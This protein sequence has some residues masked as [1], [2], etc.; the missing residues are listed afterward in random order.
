[1]FDVQ[2]SFLRSSIATPTTSTIPSEGVQAQA[3][4]YEVSGVSLAPRPGVVIALV[5][6]FLVVALIP[7]F[8]CSP[9]PL[10][11]YPNHLARMY[12]ISTLPH[13]PILQRYYEIHWQL[14][15][16][17]ALDLMVPQL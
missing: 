14:I 6:A 13:S 12:I 9:L 10:G 15:P 1:M 17:L 3:V 16:N 4:P 5:A 2:D 7:L 8:T 11:D